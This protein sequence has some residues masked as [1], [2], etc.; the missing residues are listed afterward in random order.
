M[1]SSIETKLKKRREKLISFCEILLL[2]FIGLL[3]VGVFITLT[4]KAA[5]LFF[6]SYLAVTSGIASVVLKF[7]LPKPY[8]VLRD[9]DV[10]KVFGSVPMTSTK[11]HFIRR[12][13]SYQF[14]EE[15]DAFE[16]YGCTLA[17]KRT[18]SMISQ[19]Y[20]RQESL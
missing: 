9:G 20:M 14:I 17:Y 4:F 6:V 11:G 15:K 16:R 2:A 19:N 1:E 7:F 3:I 18:E 5:L 10:V 12:R 13:E 8:I